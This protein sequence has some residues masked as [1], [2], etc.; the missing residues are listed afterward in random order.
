MTAK[1][2]IDMLS[3]ITVMW[4]PESLTVSLERLKGQDWFFSYDF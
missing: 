2:F 1:S 3:M 4:P